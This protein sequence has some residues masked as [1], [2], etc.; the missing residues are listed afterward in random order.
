MHIYTYVNNFLFSDVE[1][2]EIFTSTPRSDKKL[3]ITFIFDL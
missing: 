3:L 2:D 1:M